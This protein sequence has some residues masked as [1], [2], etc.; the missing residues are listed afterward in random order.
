M[1]I[2]YKYIYLHQYI[3]I[4]C[5]VYTVQCILYAVWYTN[6]PPSPLP[7]L[8]C[9]QLLLFCLL[10]L[11]FNCNKTIFLQL[12]KTVLRLIDY[13]RNFH[14]EVRSA[15]YNCQTVSTFTLTAYKLVIVRMTKLP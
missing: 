13:S 6:S 7:N 2:T 4:C 11:I 15:Y 10:A 12:S 8:R 5:I 14:S 9:Y 1:Y 3:F